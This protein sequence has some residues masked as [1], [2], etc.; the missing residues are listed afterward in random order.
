LQKEHGLGNA[1]K[2]YYDFGITCHLM[3]LHEKAHEYSSYKCVGIGNQNPK[4]IFEN[5]Q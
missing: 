5:M 3:K 1:D 2:D 4:T